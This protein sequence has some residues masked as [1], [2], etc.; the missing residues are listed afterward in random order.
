[1]V[2]T[3]FKL[4]S[5]FWALPSSRVLACTLHISTQS[6]PAEQT[7]KDEQSGTTNEDLAS[8]MAGVMGTQLS[9]IKIGSYADGEITSQILEN[10][11]GNGVLLAQL[12]PASTTMRLPSAHSITAVLPYY[13]HALI[14]AADVALLLEVV[15]TRGLRGGGRPAM[16]QIQCFFVPRRREPTWMRH[17]CGAGPSHDGGRSPTQELCT[18]PISFTKG[19][20]QPRGGNR[21]QLQASHESSSSVRRQILEMDLVGDVDGCARTSRSGSPSR[22]RRRSRWSTS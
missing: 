12:T 8:Q 13:G 17:V 6:A 3:K 10:A 5:S 22:C 19:P 1:M 9:A 20:R 16:Q 15:G 4:T 14:S 2:T 11:R 21:A 18:A 7:V